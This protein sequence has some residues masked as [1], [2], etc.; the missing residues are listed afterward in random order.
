MTFLTYSAIALMFKAVTLLL[1][2]IKARK[3]ATYWGTT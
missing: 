2:T 1:F 3:L